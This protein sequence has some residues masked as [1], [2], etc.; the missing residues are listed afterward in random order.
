M[1][2]KI[3]SVLAA[4]AFVAALSSVA[5]ADDIYSFTVANAGVSPSDTSYGTVDLS[6]NTTDP[7]CTVAAPCIHVAVT[8]TP[9]YGF[10]G[11]GSPMFGW[12]SS[13]SSLTLLNCSAAITDC[14]SQNT[15]SN[16]MD[17]FGS[18]GFAVNGGSGMSGAVSSFSFDVLGAG[19][20]LSGIEVLGSGGGQG[21]FPFAVQLGTTCGTGF[22]GAGTSGSTSPNGDVTPNPSSVSSSTCSGTTVPEPGTLTLLG[23]GLLGL[24]GLVRRKL[25]A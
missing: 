10:F 23:T 9:G 14:G 1:K 8:A 4:I 6:L 19:S 18:Y 11:K 13:A 5:K 15:G 12:N 25:S 7:G 21:T 20:S 22:A 17:G 2:L 16:N 24:A 3:L